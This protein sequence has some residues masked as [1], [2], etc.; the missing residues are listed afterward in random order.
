M[1]T[2]EWQSIPPRL[3]VYVGSS[4]NRAPVLGAPVRGEGWFPLTR[5]KMGFFRSAFAAGAAYPVQQ[6]SSY[7]CLLLHPVPALPCLPGKYGGHGGLGTPLK[8][9]QASHPGGILAFLRYYAKQVCCS[10][11]ITSSGGT[12]RLGAWAAQLSRDTY[13]PI[14]ISLG[15]TGREW[16]PS[17][18]H[19]LGQGQELE[20]VCVFMSCLE[21]A[22]GPRCHRAGSSHGV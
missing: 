9:Q 16:P 21:T 8:W 12:G 22:M 11:Y 3:H 7:H 5:I 1:G 19:S 15:F 13:M 18:G 17:G 2:D 4:R 10:W 6:D 14:N 20:A